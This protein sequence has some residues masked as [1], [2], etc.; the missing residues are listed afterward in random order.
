MDDA[1]EQGTDSSTPARAAFGRELI[2]WRELRRKTQAGLARRLV[3]TDWLPECSQSYV[4]HVEAGRKPP[5]RG[6]AEG[7]DAILDTGGALLRLWSWVD[8]ERH[9]GRR[10]AAQRPRGRTRER[11][12]AAGPPVAPAGDVASPVEARGAFG[13]GLPVA[14]TPSRRDDAEV[15][16]VPVLT[17][18]GRIEY[19]QIPR[20]AFLAAGGFGLAASLTSGRLHADDL[21]RLELAIETPERVDMPIVGYFRA[22]LADHRRADDLIGPQYLRVPVVV[23]LAM[24]K[25]FLGVAKDSKVK[26]ELQCVGAEYS[27]FAWWLAHDTEDRATAAEHF[28]RA[29]MWALDTGDNS[30]LGYLFALKSAEILTNGGT[31]VEAW[32]AAQ[33]AL[34]PEF[35]TTPGVRAF[36]AMRAA[37]PLALTGDLAHCRAKVEDAKALVNSVDHAKEPSWLY[38]FNEAGP[39]LTAGVCFDH[40]GRPDLALPEFS[41]A[42]Q[43][44][45]PKQ[46]RDRGEF[47]AREAAAHASAG[48][49]EQATSVAGEALQLVSETGSARNLRLLRG[50]ATRLSK[51]MDLSPV[52]DFTEQLN[53]VA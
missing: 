43:A 44:L 3:E 14:L 8:Q 42:L 21:E 20:R 10:Q 6:M 26:H 31:P 29:R 23:Q 33:A 5:P 47:L 45:P 41:A 4:A 9:D 2:H 37:R 34:R 28:D 32:H 27:Q 49:P 38:W 25:Q 40:I 36:A 30:L 17:G 53:T 16:F 52:R 24:V 15:L 35:Q 39:A 46:K 19:M 51:W 50:V 22:I 48:D 13:F 11:S 7:A 18:D 12:L 1:S